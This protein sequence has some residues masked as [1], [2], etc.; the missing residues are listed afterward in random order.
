MKKKS[1]SPT[2]SVIY[3]ILAV[4]ACFFVRCNRSEPVKVN[5]VDSAVSDSLAFGDTKWISDGLK[6][7]VY[8]LPQNTARLPLFDTMH[9]ISTIYTRTLN[10][11]P[12]SWENGFPGVPDRFEWFGIEYKADFRV[13]KSGHYKFRLLSDDGAKLFIDGKLVVDND[14]LHGPGSAY[15]ETDIDGGRHSIVVQYFQGPR[16]LIALQL[17]AMLDKEEEQVFPGDNFILITPGSSNTMVYILIIVIL[18][19]ITVTVWYI[20]KR[21]NAGRDRKVIF[22]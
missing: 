5:Q 22:T 10:I 7:K 11:T 9:P 18:I 4:L 8:F 2:L 13:K 20:R 3:F 16:Y 14:E 17:F 19:A 12:R 1:F 15:G 6:G 21:R